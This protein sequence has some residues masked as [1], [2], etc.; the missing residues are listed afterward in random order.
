MATSSTVPTAKAALV[1]LFGAALS[2]VQV[3]YGRPADNDLKRE[4]VYVGDVTGAQRIPVHSAGRKPREEAY[5]IEVVVA[6]LKTRGG[7][8]DAEERAFELLA[9]CEDVVADDSTLGIATG[10]AFFAAV[11][12]TFEVVSDFNLEGPACVVRWNVD[13]TARLV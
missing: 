12:G 6:V 7:L 5:S 13:C 11:P 3:E 2:G 8:S 9:E 4:C 10:V 1:E